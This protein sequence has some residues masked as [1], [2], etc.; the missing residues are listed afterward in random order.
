[1]PVAAEGPERARFGSSSRQGRPS[2]GTPV[3]RRPLGPFPREQTE[4]R[5]DERDT[6]VEPRL[7]ERERS[8]ITV[9]EDVELIDRREQAADDERDLQRPP[10]VLAPYYDPKGVPALHQ[11]TTCGEK[12]NPG[13]SR[14]AGDEAVEILSLLGNQGE[15]IHVRAAARHKVGTRDPRNRRL[16]G[17]TNAL[18]ASSASENSAVIDEAVWSGPKVFAELGERFRCDQLAPMPQSSEE[19]AAFT[20]MNRFCS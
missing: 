11:P 20:A 7:H 14:A 1:L 13:G 5:D 15:R 2:I 19:S 4:V 9:Q 8:R 12:L 17:R 6:E 18:V 16:P 10:Q 3:P